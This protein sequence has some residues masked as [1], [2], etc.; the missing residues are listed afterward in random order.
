MIVPSPAEGPP[1]AEGF[2]FVLTSCI[3]V[4][5]LAA[6]HHFFGLLAN[7]HNPFVMNTYGCVSKQRLLSLL[8]SALTQKRGEGGTSLFPS[9]NPDFRSNFPFGRPASFPHSAVLPLVALQPRLR[10]RVS[11]GFSWIV[12]YS[13]PFSAVSSAFPLSVCSALSRPVH[14]PRPTRPRAT[15][16]GACLTPSLTK[17]SASSPSSLVP[18]MTPDISSLSRKVSLPA[19]LS[20]ANKVVAASYAI[21]AT[22]LRQT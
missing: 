20:S 16:T 4:P 2:L 14:R 3:P 15:A 6:S 17:T 7:S 13:L 5:C 8:E 9:Q 19:K 21:A 18:P 10:S 11:G 12:P 1:G 22:A